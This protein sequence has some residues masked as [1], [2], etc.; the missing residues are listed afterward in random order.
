MTAV[1]CAVAANRPAAMPMTIWA[2][3]S[4]RKELLVAAMMLPATKRT[5]A[6]TTTRLRS[7]APVSVAR[8]GVPIA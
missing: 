1:A 5:S 7:A 2:D 3:V 6:P 8:I 4:T